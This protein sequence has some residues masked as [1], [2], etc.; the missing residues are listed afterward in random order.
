M[1]Q[2][3]IRI[4]IFHDHDFPSFQQ[5]DNIFSQ[6]PS[7][8]SKDVGGRRGSISSVASSVPSRAGSKAKGVGAVRESQDSMTEKERIAELARKY[9]LPKIEGVAR[10]QTFRRNGF[11]KLDDY[12]EGELEQEFL[13]RVT[14]SDEAWV[15][16][17]F[18]CNFFS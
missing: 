5:T 14:Q 15:G 10:V 8:S 17:K 1:T 2:Q 6:N 7:Q 9:D 16:T 11:K 18:C 4:E 3:H 13:T 12:S